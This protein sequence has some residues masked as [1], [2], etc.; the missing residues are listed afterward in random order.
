MKTFDLGHNWNGTRTK[1]HISDNEMILQDHQDCQAILDENAAMRNMPQA[2]SIRS[3]YLAARIP[4]TIYYEWKKDWRANH[5]DK[6]TWHTYL[7][8]KVNS[9]DW[10][11]L[12]VNER[13]M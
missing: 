5:R 13:R 11:K 1:L 4:V 12:K 7:A 10:C 3:G 2:R 9:R 6:W 8:M